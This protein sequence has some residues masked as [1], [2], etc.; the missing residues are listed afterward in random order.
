MTKS[1]VD[2]EPG[3]FNTFTKHV[4]K[5]KKK[6]LKADPLES[7]ER[8]IGPVEKGMNIFFFNSGQFSLSDVIEHVLKSIGPADLYLS[9]WTAS[10]D[11]L[12]KAFMFLQNK[13]IKSVKFMVDRGFK[14]FKGKPYKYLFDNFGPDCIRTT[15]I[16]A[17]FVVLQNDDF[18]IVIRTSANLNRNRRLENFELTDDLEFAEFF[19]QF[20][21]EAWSQIRV[22]D[23]FELASSQKLEPVLDKMKGNQQATFG[24]FE[25]D[26]NFG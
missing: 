26:Y 7:V 21:D 11:G 8:L 23:N 4:L 5:S 14:Q 16:H 18:N 24:D 1:T 9:T 20:F 6:I 15:R 12:E 25:M 19:K 13:M 10:Q 2:I 22:T 17:K 3:A